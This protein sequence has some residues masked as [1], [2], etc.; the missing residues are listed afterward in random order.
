MAKIALRDFDLLFV[1]KRFKIFISE[2]VRASAKVCGR[3][4]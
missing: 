2:T 4:L 3:H 1:A